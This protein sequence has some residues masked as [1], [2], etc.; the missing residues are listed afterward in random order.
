MNAIEIGKLGTRVADDVVGRGVHRHRFL[1][2]PL[3]P[4]DYRK[5]AC[6]EF[7]LTDCSF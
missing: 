3:L 2:S 6:V 4:D 5:G 7:C 1:H